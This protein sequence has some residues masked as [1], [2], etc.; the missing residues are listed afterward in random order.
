MPPTPFQGRPGVGISCPFE[1]PAK[2]NREQESPQ[3]KEAEPKAKQRRQENGT[4]MTTEGPEVHGQQD[5]SNGRQRAVRPTKA[6]EAMAKGKIFQYVCPHCKQPVNSTIRTGQ[7]NHRR[8]CGKQYDYVCPACNGHVASNVA[9][10]QINHRTVCGNQFSVQDGAVK[11]KGVVYRCPFCKGN[12]RSDVRTGQID[13]RTVCGNKFSVQDGAVTEKGVVDRCL[14]CKGNVRSDVRTGRIDHRTVCGNQFYVKDSAVSK[15][16]RCHAHSCPVCSTAVWSSQSCGRIA[17]TQVTPSGKRCQMKHW[18]V[19]DKK[20][21]KK[22]KWNR[23]TALAVGT[24]GNGKTSA[25]KHLRGLKAGK[26][27]ECTR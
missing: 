23:K 20:A 10:G 22:R 16:T 13:H 21:K 7:A 4:E 11:E 24:D 3:T 8:T 9:T 27:K 18:H 5:D 26:R 1:L 2:R 19:P 14:F 6:A 15:N 25:A 12:V 17:V